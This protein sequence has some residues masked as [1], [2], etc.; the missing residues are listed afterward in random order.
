MLT[1]LDHCKQEYC[2]SIMVYSL[3]MRVNVS[4]RERAREHGAPGE[5]KSET[6]CLPV[7]VW[8]HTRGWRGLEVK[9]PE[10]QISTLSNLSL[11]RTPAFPQK[12]RLL[13]ECG[14][15]GNE[16]RCACE[17]VWCRTYRTSVALLHVLIGKVVNQLQPAG[18]HV[19]PEW[20]RGHLTAVAA[21]TAAYRSKN[22][23]LVKSGWWPN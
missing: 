8:L 16:V 5:T 19:T 18:H 11:S 20:K 14:F 3:E 10:T 12:M 22:K 15:Q 1:A 2:V 17:H 13:E 6:S 4:S 21:I 9:A 7:R 23:T